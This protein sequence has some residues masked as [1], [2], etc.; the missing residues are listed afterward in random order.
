MS[1]RAR[2]DVQGS[3]VSAET[4]IKGRESIG[5]TGHFH[6][7]GEPGEPGGRCQLRPCAGRWALN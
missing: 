5:Q 1:D 6:L 7:P 2:A 3:Q 4:G